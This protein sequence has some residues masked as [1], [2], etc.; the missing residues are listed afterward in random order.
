M[1]SPSSIKLRSLTISTKRATMV[2][3]KRGDPTTKLTGVKC[4]RLY[5]ISGEQQQRLALN[6]PMITWQCFVAAGTDIRA[7]DVVTV[8]SKDYVVRAVELWRDCLHVFI[9]ES[10]A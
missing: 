5:P 4:T 2:S 3:G 6:S 10:K 1:P 7:N 8:A 9:E